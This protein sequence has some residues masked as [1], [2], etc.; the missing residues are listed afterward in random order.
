[1]ARGDILLK[2]I[3]FILLVPAFI[4]AFAANVTGDDT[5]FYIGIGVFCVAGLTDVVRKGVGK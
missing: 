4:L 3:T 5:Y 2:P 1:V